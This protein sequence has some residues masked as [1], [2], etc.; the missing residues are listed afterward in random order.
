[1]KEK[2]EVKKGEEKKKA[3]SISLV[4]HCSCCCVSS[5]RDLQRNQ[6]EVT[7]LYVTEN[8]QHPIATASDTDAVH[9]DL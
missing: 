2:Q 5:K 9:G 7:R 4:K 1:M 3:V 8:H 6:W